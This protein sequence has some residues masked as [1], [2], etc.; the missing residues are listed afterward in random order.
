MALDWCPF[1]VKHP[2]VSDNFAVGRNGQCVKAVVLHIAA[3]P[4]T[5]VFPTFNNPSRHTSAHFCIGKNGMIEQYV[6]VNDTAYANGLSWVNNQW[7]NAR[8]KIVQPTW[9]DIVTKFNPNLYTISIEHEG[10]SDDVWTAEMYEANQQLLV[11]LA[12]QF[13]LTYVP[14]HTLI[15]HCE[16]D[17]VDKVNCPGSH[18]EYDKMSQEVAVLRATRQVI[19]PSPSNEFEADSRPLDACGQ[20][21]WGRMRKGDDRQS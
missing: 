5:A 15:G 21:H 8:G 18:V 9:P 7:Q 6:P 13:K 12:D 3:G 11:W 17:P 16:I 4:L 20:E 10:Q 2:I 14:H 1:A 19:A